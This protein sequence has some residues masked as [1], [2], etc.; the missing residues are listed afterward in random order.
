M[1]R[2]GL[3][4]NQIGLVR[5][6]GYP[7]GMPMSKQR[8]DVT[9]LLSV[10]AAGCA[11]ALG[12]VML[13]GGLGLVLA[14]STSAQPPL[15]FVSAAILTGVGAVNVRAGL[16]LWNRR[17]RALVPSAVATAGLLAYVMVIGDLGEP[18]FLHLWYLALL[19]GLAYSGRSIRATA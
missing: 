15:Q 11:V 7:R 4:I 1:C 12:G 16:Q 2:A 6:P 9:A 18:F 5:S 17:Q 10:V 19:A 14:I 13:V 3:R 8:A